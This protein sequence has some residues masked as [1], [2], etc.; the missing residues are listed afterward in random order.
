MTTATRP[1]K[2]EDKPKTIAEMTGDELET[3]IEKRDKQFKSE[4]RNLRAL[5]KCV[6]DKE[7]ATV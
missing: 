4:Q 3:L 1:P 5:L 6:R 2:T 7:A